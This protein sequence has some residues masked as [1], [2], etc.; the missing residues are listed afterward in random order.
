MSARD[1][2]IS[3]M[4]FTMGFIIMSIELLGGRI[5]APWFGSSVAVWGSIIT[6]FMLSLSCGYYLGGVISLRK[7]SLLRYAVI[8]AAASIALMPFTTIDEPIMD[9]IFYSMEDVR[10]ASLLAAVALFMLPTTLMGMAA[11]YSVRL[12]TRSGEESGHKAGNLY[13]IST[14]GSAGGT[15]LTSFYFVL[16]WEIDTIIYGMIGALLFTAVFAAGLASRGIVS[17]E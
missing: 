1:I 3:V 6:V 4:A 10:W 15:L 17:N 16:W 7:P 12:M 11:P 5:L 2:L 14:I 9:S 13:F 8:F